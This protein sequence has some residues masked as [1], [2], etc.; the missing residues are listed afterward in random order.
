MFSLNDFF[1]NFSLDDV[2]FLSDCYKD[3]VFDYFNNNSN[4]VYDYIIFDNLNSIYI[5]FSTYNNFDYI[6]IKINYCYL[7]QQPI[8]Y[9]NFVDFFFY[10]FIN[11]TIDKLIFFYFAKI[12]NFTCYKFFYTLYFTFFSFTT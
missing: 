1:L 3:F 4:L 7:T 6:K 5:D 11:F 9:L 2:F 12:F 8:L 10:D